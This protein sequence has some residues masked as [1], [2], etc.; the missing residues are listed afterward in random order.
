MQ[1]FC[2]FINLFAY[3]MVV[4]E[5]LINVITKIYRMYIECYSTCTNNSYFYPT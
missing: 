5:E 4:R 1:L 3:N 2:C